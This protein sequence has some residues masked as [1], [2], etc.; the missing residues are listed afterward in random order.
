MAEGA[1]VTGPRPVREPC[2]DVSETHS[3]VV[4]F[5]GDRAFKLKK[6]VILGFLDFSTRGA[7]MS[8]C[9]REIE[10]N[11]RFAPD[12]YLGVIEVRDPAGQVCD[13][14]V[15]MRRMPASGGS[16]P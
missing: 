10:L 14:L 6:P 15:A 8:A 1:G 9:Q 4:F 2:A 11:R 5:T 13:H 3:A 12:V 16:P 7:R